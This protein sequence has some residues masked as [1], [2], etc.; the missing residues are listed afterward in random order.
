MAALRGGNKGLQ[1]LTFE[2]AIQ[3]TFRASELC[4]AEKRVA[5]AADRI[6]RGAID[7]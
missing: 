6:A 2:T 4:C 3:F 7:R 5:V 1:T